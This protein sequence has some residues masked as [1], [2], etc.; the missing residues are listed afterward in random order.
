M[1]EQRLLRRVL[2]EVDVAQDPVRHRVEPVARGD[3][4]ARE[5]LLVTVLRP[6]DEIGIHVF[7]RLA[8]RSCRAFTGMGAVDDGLTHS[9]RRPRPTGSRLGALSVPCPLHEDPT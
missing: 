7:R 1:V 4:E 6:S 9:S 5:G 3:G 8:A 2:G